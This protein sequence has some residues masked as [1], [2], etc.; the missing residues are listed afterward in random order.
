MR[1]GVA[2]SAALAILVC[3]VAI[4]SP[5]PTQGSVT[6][7]P[8]PS[9]KGCVY[10]KR[11]YPPTK[12]AF[13]RHH[14]T[15]KQ[16][17]YIMKYVQKI[18]KAERSYAKW[19]FDEEVDNQLLIFDAFPVRPE[20]AIGSHAAWTAENTNLVLDPIECQMIITPVARSAGQSPI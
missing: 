9:A 18:P 4:A 10:F 12:Q 1:Q 14:L 20:D 16:Q 2:V 7:T 19:M 17:S 15:G 5:S 11:L 13:D 3:F 8:M 6:P